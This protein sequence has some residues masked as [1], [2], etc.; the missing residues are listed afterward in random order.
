MTWEAAMSQFSWT[1][2]RGDRTV[3][4][5]GSSGRARCAHVCRVV[6]ARRPTVGG[7]RVFVAFVER[8]VVRIDRRTAPIRGELDLEMATRRRLELCD[9]ARRLAQQLVGDERG[10]EEARDVLAGEDVVELGQVHVGRDR[11]AAP[12]QPKA[13]L[14]RSGL[15]D[16]GLERHD[17]NERAER[18]R[19]RAL[20]VLLGHVARRRDQQ[21][22]AERD[23]AEEVLARRRTLLWRIED[24][25]LLAERDR[26]EEIAGEER[27][28]PWTL[29]VLLVVWP[30]LSKVPCDSERAF[31]PKRSQRVGGSRISRPSARGPASRRHPHAVGQTR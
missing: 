10:A 12:K 31:V 6:R 14:D 30:V 13:S 26:L 20:A 18:V 2:V 29:P 5:S 8:E 28:R 1:N 15:R 4:L 7:K 21:A 17:R 25:R 16:D 11:V 23:L 27:S 22:V 19:G 9:A 3:D 24:G